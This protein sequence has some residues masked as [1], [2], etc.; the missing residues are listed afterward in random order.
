MTLDDEIRSRLRADR[1]TAGS[2][3]PASTV[4]AQLQP[5]LRR[6]RRMRRTRRVV[7]GATGAVLI[8][9]TGVALQF[10][11]DLR[12][13][14]I[15]TYGESGRIAGVD[16]PLSE[17]TSPQSGSSQSGTPPATIEDPTT[18]TST[19]V[20]ASPGVGVPAATTPGHPTSTQPPTPAA[21]PN[22]IDSACGSIVVEFVNDRVSLVEV[23]ANPGFEVD[24]KSDG[25]QNVEVGMHRGDV[26]C[27]LRTRVIDGRLVTAVRDPEVHE[28]EEHEPE[29]SEPEEHE[30]EDSEPEE[31]E[32][33]DSEPG[34]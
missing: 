33:E 28:P 34:A 23:L 2:A 6:A 13:K 16:D 8:G 29:D 1:G 25:P 4:F 17:A 21:V 32:P 22:R 10:G 5:R 7:V 15:R 14:T 20:S 31:H 24:V 26:E 9:A 27:E 11:D 19:S 30:P 18:S 12:S 3:P